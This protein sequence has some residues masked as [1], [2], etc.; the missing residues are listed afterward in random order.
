MKKKKV[1]DI[2][3]PHTLEKTKPSLIVGKKEESVLIKIEPKL[4][5]RMVEEE[6]ERIR[7]EEDKI[8]AEL[9]SYE[10]PLA[11][12][13]PRLAKLSLK[14]KLLSIIIPIICIGLFYYL[15][16]AVLTK[17]EIDITAK[18]LNLSL[19]NFEVLI[20]KNVSES[21]YSQKVIPGN[22]F[23]F[24]ESYE[25]EFQSTGQGKDEVRAKGVITIINNYSSS[26]QI[27]V[28]TTRFETSDG[29]IFRLDSRVVIPGA[30]SKDGKLQPSSIDVNVTADKPGPDYNISACTDSCKFTIPGFK[31]TDKFEGFYGISSKPMTGGSL[32]SVPMVTAD[33]LK[34]SE[35][36][37]LE[38]INQKISEDVQ[39][40]IPSTLAII[41]GA[42]SGVKIEKLTSDVSIGD[43][44][45]TFKVTAA[46]EVSV[47][48]FRN[49]DLI[50]LVQNQFNAQKPDKYD[51]C[52]NPT[53]EYLRVNPDFKTGSL[54]LT[55]SV[56][57]II[58]FHLN[59]D[60]IKS[61]IAGKNQQE[62][63]VVLNSLDGVEQVK[64]K[65]F[66]FWLKSVPK[67]L[68]KI[69]IKID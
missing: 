11:K 68:N 59:T 9:S 53:I 43:F 47:I 24:P 55:L 38:V 7:S 20:D 65:L 34:N 14:T 10:S 12:E 13:L 15:G 69:N 39:T 36:T 44:R 56:K 49:E 62:L 54:K 18:K 26:P 1:I 17:A 27:L 21:N 3:P 6:P 64:A 60:E 8:I 37:I 67:N 33:D 29:K 42:K 50:N 61:S 48:A 51:Y 22:L 4:K 32:G 5:K 23:V 52:Q 35:N 40:K 46:G 28:A 41:D 63:T 66:P 31:G 57:Q 2:Y 25:Q 19:D 58:C 45:Q 16:F 30:S